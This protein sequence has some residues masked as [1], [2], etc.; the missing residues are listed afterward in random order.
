M[1]VEKLLWDWIL[2]TLFDDDIFDV[3]KIGHYLMITMLM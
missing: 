1:E 2:Q 3:K